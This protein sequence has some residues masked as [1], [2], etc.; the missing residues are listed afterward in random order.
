M[1]RK[2]RTQIVGVGYDGQPAGVT[3]AV[4][5]KT[6]VQFLPPTLREQT[7]MTRD[8]LYRQMEPERRLVARLEAMREAENGDDAAFLA[9]MARAMLAEIQELSREYLVERSRNVT[10][11]AR[12]DRLNSTPAPCSPASPPAPPASCSPT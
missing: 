12:L 8:E 2:G 6:Q 1:D 7:G 9:S 4:A 10:L 11:Q 3:L 5:R